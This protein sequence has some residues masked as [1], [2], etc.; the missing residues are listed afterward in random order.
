MQGT[1]EPIDGAISSV[2][3]PDK[4][5]PGRCRAPWRWQ[6]RRSNRSMESS[7]SGWIRSSNCLASNSSLACDRSAGI[8]RERVTGERGTRTHPSDLS[9]LRGG[10]HNHRTPPFG[11]DH[12][13][14]ILSSKTL[15]RSGEGVS[16]HRCALHSLIRSDLTDSVSSTP[17][18]VRSKDP[19]DVAPRTPQRGALGSFLS[20]RSTTRDNPQRCS[21]W[22]LGLDQIIVTLRRSV[23][24]SPQARSQTK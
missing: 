19:R 12:V 22:M 8:T 7:Q 3:S 16:R 15:S 2:T 20:T 23:A 11:R 14:S 6:P 17:R 13:E 10:R 5:S 24:A 21:C 18:T 1:G 9:V 4:R